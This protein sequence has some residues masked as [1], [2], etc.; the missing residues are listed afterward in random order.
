MSIFRRVSLMVVL[1]VGA[2]AF[3]FGH[4][5]AA[6]SVL[7]PTSCVRL[8]ANGSSGLEYT[9][10]GVKN[11]VGMPVNVVCSLFRDNTTNTD[12]MQDLEVSISDPNPLPGILTCTAYSFDRQGV[13][14]KQLEKKATTRG[15]VILDWGS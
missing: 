5:R 2:G 4:A 14:K 3:V 1:V 9:S 10:D 11:V 8:G 13:I 6:T 15:N 7:G 12:G